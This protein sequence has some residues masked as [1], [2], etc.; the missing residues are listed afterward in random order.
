MKKFKHFKESYDFNNNIF[1][2]NVIDKYSTLTAKI[3]RKSGFAYD[4]HVSLSYENIS[5]L[6]CSVYESK[7]KTKNGFSNHGENWYYD[8]SSFK[9]LNDNPDYYQLSYFNYPIKKLIMLRD[10]K[11]HHKRELSIFTIL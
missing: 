2:N 8:V 9:K 10:K 5:K 3:I 11:K 7:E 4:N 1:D 6:Y